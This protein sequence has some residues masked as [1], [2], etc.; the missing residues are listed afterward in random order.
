MLSGDIRGQ[1]GDR[2]ILCEGGPSL[3][4]SLAE[5][6]QVDELCLTYAPVLAGP[7]PARI[8]AGPEQPASPL[9]IG[10]VLE[11]DGF[12]FVRYAVGD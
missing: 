11:E 8:I 10:H 6:G 7:G 2:R 5:E 12:L 1:L 4:G 3:F 9:R